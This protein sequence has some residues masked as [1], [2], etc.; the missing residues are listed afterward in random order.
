MFTNHIS[1][2]R[3]RACPVLADRVPLAAILVMRKVAKRQNVLLQP[4]P[5]S[6]KR[7]EQ[8]FNSLLMK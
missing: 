3:L 1:G 4:T 5:I 2:M 7:L 8:F 6:M